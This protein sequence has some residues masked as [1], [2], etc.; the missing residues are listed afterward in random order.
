MKRK[1]KLSFQALLILTMFIVSS[2]AFTYSVNPNL[3][4]EGASQSIMFF[5]NGQVSAMRS[6]YPLQGQSKIV[7]NQSLFIMGNTNELVGA[8]YF[9]DENENFHTIDAHGFMYNKTE[10][11]FE[12]ESSI[13]VAGGNYF[14]DSSENL[15]VVKH[16]GFIAQYKDALTEKYKTSWGRT[17]TRTLE[18][19]IVG[20]TY[21]ITKSHRLFVIGFD[22]SYIEKTKFF[23]KRY[24]SVKYTGHNYFITKDGS[25][26][27]IGTVPMLADSKDANKIMKDGKPLYKTDA[28]GNIQYFQ[29]LRKYDAVKYR[30]VKVLGG[31]FFFDSKN[32]IHTVSSE[33]VLDRGVVNRKLKVKFDK[34]N[35]SRTRP[36]KVGANYFSYRDGSLFTVSADGYYYFIKK[37]DRRIEQ[38]NFTGRYKND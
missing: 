29:M 12:I 5:D 35:K 37:L 24:D 2:L 36:V 4:T 38:T 17:R 6:Y 26:F 15:Y 32:N 21:F 1:L 14:I 18:I 3:P 28:F 8:N 10:V 23:G 11:G 25:V 20:G 13:E 30:R 27:T 19:K 16:D 33:G 7:D 22:G 31:N 9:I 34:L